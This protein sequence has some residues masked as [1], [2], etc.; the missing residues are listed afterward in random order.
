MRR[1]VHHYGH[2]K[3]GFNAVR[4]A[5]L[6]SF[7]TVSGVIIGVASV[8]VVVSIGEGI[9][10]QI[11]GQLHSLGNDLITIRPAQFQPGSD[12][13]VGSI[14]QFSGFSVSTPLTMKDVVTVA[15]TPGVA[16]STPLTYVG[17]TV[18]SDVN[19]RNAGFV[20]GTSSALP[21][22]IN[23]SMA[24]G[25]FF[26]D[27]DAGQNV[28]ILGPNISEQLFDEDVPL[29]R[30]FS[31]HGQT[32]IVRGIF[33]QFNFTP[34]SQQANFN[35]AI[36]IPYDVAQGL[37][38][39]TAPTY[40][41]LA[42]ASSVPQSDQVA[43]RIKAS[44]DGVHGGSSNFSIQSGSQ[45]ATDS[46]TIL[47]LLTKLVAG[48]AAISLLVGGIGIMNVMMVAIGERTRE[49]GI[50]KAVG[51]TNRQIL[52]QFL[53]ESMILGLIGGT[54]GAALAILTD[55]TLRLVSNLRPV[56]SWQII[57]LATGISLAV[58]MLF[59]TYPAVKAA[60][61]DPIQALR[62]E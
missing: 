18:K 40:E 12:A 41:I 22:L 19:S 32:F 23:Q 38:N 51:A 7:W 14:G 6:R 35:N 11:G 25:S 54:I 17:G 2:L 61:K 21:S 58:G 3:A 48:V 31:F 50:R 28:A 8:I 44:L 4:S 49:I 43:G 53:M 52:G 20:I 16:A 9:K 45:N 46:N 59:G 24:Y 30:S 37:S 13:R 33:N 56:I 15:H 26:D 27:V 39:N 29:G 34:L 42:R 55:L 57:L 47:D 10:Q 1:L 62:S 36:F 60:R 5:K